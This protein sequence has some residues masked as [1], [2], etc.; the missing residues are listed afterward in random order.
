MPALRDLLNDLT[1]GD[2]VRAENAASALID[3]GEEAIPAL[4]DLTRSEDVDDRWWGLRV[5]IGRA[6][7]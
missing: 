1:S 6:H 3:L 5:Q 2:E 4:L 7:V